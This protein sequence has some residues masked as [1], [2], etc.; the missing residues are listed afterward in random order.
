MNIFKKIKL[1]NSIVKK[2]EQLKK[3]I[4]K[5]KELKEEIHNTIEDINV[6][7]PIFKELF[8]DIKELIK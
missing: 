5:N 6:K 2:A 3:I 4:D 8:E 1:I 7:H